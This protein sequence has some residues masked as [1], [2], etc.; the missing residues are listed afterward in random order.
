MSIFTR[1][2]RLLFGRPIAT[3]FAHHERLPKIYGLPVFAS[4]ALSSVAYASEEIL[5]VLVLG[6]W[7]AYT[8]LVPISFALVC[9]LWIVVFSYWQTIHAYPQGGG[10][11]RVSSE[12]IGP[13]AGLLAGAAL[14]IGY[15]LTVAVSVSAGA[16]AIVSMFPNTQNYI[17]IIAC[18]AVAII[19]ILNLRGAKE[20]GAVF[21][22]P[23]YSFVVFVI[24]MVIF[25]AY[26]AYIGGQQPIPPNLPTPVAQDISIAFIIAAF[27]RG[28]TALTGTEAIADGVQAFKAPE[29]QNASLTL[30]MMASLLTV[31]VLGISW[32]AQYFG[33]VPMHFGEEGYRTVIA[34]IALKLFGETWPF[35]A[36]LTVTALI[37]FL[38]ANTGFADFPRLSQ[39]MARD[40]Y[41]PRQLMSVGDKLVYQNGIIAL[42]LLSIALIVVFQ[43]S[44]HLLIPLYAAGVF[45]S[46]TLSQAGMVG[47]LMKTGGSWKM[48]VSGLGAIATGIVTAILMIT[49]FK[50][51][52]WILVVALAVM[53]SICYGIKRHYNY[54][55]KELTVG[56]ED[57][58]QPLRTTV[59]LLVPRVHRGILHAISYAKSL[60]KD[61]RAVHVTL[62]PKSVHTVKDDW[63]RFS[64]DIPLVILDSPYR[65]L[66]EPVI[67]YIDQTIAEDP[68]LMVTVI[69]PQAVPVRWWQGLLH[70]NAAMGLKMALKSRK[71]VVITNV[72]YFLRP[73]QG[74]ELPPDH[75]GAVERFY[76]ENQNEARPSE[77]HI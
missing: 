2:K 53:I 72:R 29:P 48:Y 71:N 62:D 24:G 20:S 46:F 74:D 57:K 60:A 1:M 75:P 56:P 52:A 69:V 40:G 5:L 33:V 23:T 35:Y 25:G 73:S 17:V 70:N 32:A 34:Q 43:A 45:L 67:E 10:S 49:R 7:A 59:L 16:S 21:A 6:G 51:G 13:W 19:T 9:L 77:E 42:A 54:L 47:K 64:E 55:A 44:T 36:I 61:V 76:L 37:L 4:D 66:I 14:L 38:A 63:L 50:E 18:G 58:V 15:V 39:F 27:A 68:G 26:K 8:K 30:V 31:L 65:S 28:C 12:N 22:V 3:K 41:L 11:Y